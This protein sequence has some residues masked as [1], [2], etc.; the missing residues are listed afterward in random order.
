MSLYVLGD[1]HKRKDLEKL[2]SIDHL[3]DDDYVLITGDFGITLPTLDKEM[4][5][6]IEKKNFTTLFIDGNHEGFSCLNSYPIKI[7][8]NGMIHRIS[9][10][11][12]HLMRGQVFEIEGKRIFTFGGAQTLDKLDK[13]EG[14]EWWKEELPTYKEMDEGIKNLKKYNNTV[15]YI[16][17]HDTRTSTLNYLCSMFNFKPYPDPLNE[18][19]EDIYNSVEFRHWYFGHFHLDLENI[20]ENEETL[21]FNNLIKVI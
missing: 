2:L 3:K 21:V 17:T 16:F 4:L 5:E 1:T 14:I 11:V 12:I 7:W 9:N 20:K 6:E 8:N 19:L 18:Y 15:D 10:K 13:K